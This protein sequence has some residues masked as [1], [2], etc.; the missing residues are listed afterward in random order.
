MNLS[1][2]LHIQRLTLREVVFKVQS[3]KSRHQYFRFFWKKVVNIAITELGLISNESLGN[4][5]YYRGNLKFKNHLFFF[6]LKNNG[7]LNFSAI[8]TISQ[9]NPGNDNYSIKPLFFQ[10]EL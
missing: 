9:K 1:G 5:T 8:I 2:W 3:V 7:F 10:K 6:F 4:P